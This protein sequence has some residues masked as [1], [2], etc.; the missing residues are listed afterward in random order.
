MSARRPTNKTTKQS[1]GQSSQRSELKRK[2]T[3]FGE[4]DNNWKGIKTNVKTQ[5]KKK[6]SSR[7]TKKIKVNLKSTKSKEKHEDTFEDKVPS[8]KNL[9]ALAQIHSQDHQR[10][11]SRK[12]EFSKHRVS[13]IRSRASVIGNPMGH[14]KSIVQRRGTRFNSRMVSKQNLDDSN[15]GLLNIKEGERGSR[16]MNTQNGSITADMNSHRNREMD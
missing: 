14:K 3:F 6:P 4:N 8:M 11:S 12:S 15:L 9:E 2:G 13:I 5:I 7:G 10:S 1:T 16:V